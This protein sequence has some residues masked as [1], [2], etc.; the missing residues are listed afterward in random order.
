V[1][2]MGG[3]R[4]VKAKMKGCCEF[5]YGRFVQTLGAWTR[6]LRGDLWVRKSRG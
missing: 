6:K 2:R 3:G 1:Q 4:D 5:R